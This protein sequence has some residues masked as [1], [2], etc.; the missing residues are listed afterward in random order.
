MLGARRKLFARC[1]ATTAAMP[2]YQREIARWRA[3]EYLL[4]RRAVE[5]VDALEQ[6]AEHHPVVGEHGVVAVLEQARLGNLDL[7]TR[8]PAT[9]DGAAE[10][11]VDAAVAVVGALVAVLAEGPPELGDHDDEGVAP[12]LRSE[13][14]HIAG[15]R[16]AE[17]AEAAGEIAV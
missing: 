10:H 14:L 6:A 13:F 3:G 5:A 9:F 15:K 17:L 16:A 8:E 4:E 12:R 1:S 11:P 7:L 2:S